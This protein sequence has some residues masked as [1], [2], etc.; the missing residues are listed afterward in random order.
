MIKLAISVEG[1]TPADSVRLALRHVEDFAGMIPDGG[2]AK[3][4]IRAWTNQAELE[5]L[6]ERRDRW[7]ARAQTA[8]RERDELRAEVKAVDDLADLARERDAKSA[9]CV[10][11]GGLLDDACR[12]FGNIAHTDLSGRIDATLKALAD[13]TREREEAR[14]KALAEAARMFD[15]LACGVGGPTAGSASWAAGRVYAMIDKPAADPAPANATPTEHALLLAI[16][17]AVQDIGSHLRDMAVEA[18]RS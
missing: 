12:H 6:T 16:L 8:E 18:L 14:R 9:E 3:A 2:K 1:E 13:R 4:V 10:R 15:E 5:Q 11:F 17:T 7:R